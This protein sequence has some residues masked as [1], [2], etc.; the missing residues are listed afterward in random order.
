MPFGLL[1]DASGERDELIMSFFDDLN[2]AAVNNAGLFML[3]HMIQSHNNAS[4]MQ[5]IAKSQAASESL[6]AESNSLQK[7]QLRIQEEALRFE[8]EREKKE[9]EIQETRAA[10]NARAEADLKDFRNLLSYSE[11]MIDAESNSNEFILAT[12]EIL[13]IMLHDQG[14]RAKLTKADTDSFMTFRHRLFSCRQNFM[15]V[16]HGPSCVA[17][18]TKKLMFYT[19]NLSDFVG[20]QQTWK[21]MFIILVN[22]IYEPIKNPRLMVY[23]VAL[24]EGPFR[25]FFPSGYSF[26]RAKSALKDRFGVVKFADEDVDQLKKKVETGS[27]SIT[28][29]ADNLAIQ[30]TSSLQENL[31][32]D[33]CAV[34]C[35][36][37]QISIDD[38]SRN[39]TSHDVLLALTRSSCT[40]SLH[41][42]PEIQLFLNILSYVDAH[43]SGRWT[44]SIPS[45]T[46]QAY[47]QFIDILTLCDREVVEANEAAI[48]LRLIS[49]HQLLSFVEDGIESIKQSNATIH[50]NMEKSRKEAIQERVSEFKRNSAS[51]Y[52]DVRLA[53]PVGA[54]TLLS[55][56]DRTA[57]AE[58]VAMTEVGNIA[59]AENLF[60]EL[61][62]KSNMQATVRSQELLQAIEP[63]RAAITEAKACLTKVEHASTVVRTEFEKLSAPA[64]RLRSLRGNGNI[65][66]V[67]LEQSLKYM[68][69]IVIQSSFQPGSELGMRINVLVANA[70]PAC[71]AANICF[72]WQPHPIPIDGYVSRLQTRSNAPMEVFLNALCAIAACDGDFCMAEQKV[73]KEIINELRVELPD[74]KV[75]ASIFSFCREARQGNL[76]RVIAQSIA[77]LRTLQNTQLASQLE[78]ALKKM[79]F[80]DGNVAASEKQVFQQMMNTI[81]V[82]EKSA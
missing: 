50:S 28:K 77:D 63:L 12:L 38:G 68:H 49:S 58:A 51:R 41:V 40:Q 32:F 81:S 70:Q 37:D 22:R 26:E 45:A 62:K 65:A 19:G 80:A 7:A 82:A 15:T 60:S 79:V 5:A 39:L 74:K 67:A 43:D 11:L 55:N 23:A 33:R 10:E 30:I 46:L 31:N 20:E 57:I 1:K 2:D 75:S 21:S 4:R 9:R 47:Q 36:S 17:A 52:G 71:R 78:N 24:T 8:R 6:Q 29:D 66:T 16:N 42:D 27:A 69:S 14:K 3:G 25:S 13:Y 18:A 64:A 34:T 54:N 35:L 56:S 59:E 72:N 73:V 61:H 53:K 48:Q 44:Q 76:Q